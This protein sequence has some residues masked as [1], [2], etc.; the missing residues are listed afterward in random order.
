MNRYLV[1]STIQFKYRYG[2]FSVDFLARWMSVDTFA[3]IIETQP[4]AVA[5][6]IV[7][8]NVCQ[9][10]WPAFTA[11][12]YSFVCTSKFYGISSVN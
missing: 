1:I 2:A 11:H 5:L 10:L 3:L 6:L 8:I 9:Q 7:L 4:L 12:K